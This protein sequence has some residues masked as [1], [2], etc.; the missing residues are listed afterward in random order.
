MLDFLEWLD[1]DQ[2]QLSEQALFRVMDSLENCSVDPRERVI[3]W[4]DGKRL[5]IAQT[6]KRIHSQSNLPIREIESHVVGWL[7]MHYEPPELDEQQ[8]EQFESM[9]DSWVRDHEGA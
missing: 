5:S 1:S 6:A 8:M 2:G 7:E 4:N 3:V 9:I